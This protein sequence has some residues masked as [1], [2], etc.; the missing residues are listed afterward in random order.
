M[1]FPAISLFLSDW[2]TYMDTILSHKIYKYIRSSASISPSMFH[3]SSIFNS[4]FYSSFTKKSCIAIFTTLFSNIAITEVD[5]YRTLINLDTSK[6]TGRDGIP[7]IVLLKCAS[8]LYKP[9]HCLFCLTLKYGWKYWKELYMTNLLIIFLT[10]FNLV[11]YKTDQL[12]NNFFFLSN[13]F[14]ISLMSFT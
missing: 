2:V 3:D 10:R 6:A 11:S 5:V 7:S 8:A 14:V 4:Y 1:Y 9:L 13:V 12:P